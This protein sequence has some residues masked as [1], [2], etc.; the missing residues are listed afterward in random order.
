[1]GDGDDDRGRRPRHRH[2]PLGD[3]RPGPDAAVAGGARGSLRPR[4]LLAGLPRRPPAAPPAP[5]PPPPAPPPPPPPTPAPPPPPP[6]DA[7]P[8]RWAS[9]P[10]DERRARLVHRRPGLP[11]DPGGRLRRLPQPGA[12]AA[13]RGRP[14]LPRGRHGRPLRPG[15]H[16]RARRRRGPGR[17]GA[18]A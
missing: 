4:A 15:H 9:W 6:P 13:R 11:V 16:L 5:G 3:P 8:S 1:G 10:G 17:R 12:R 18:R 7:A 14:H 2:V